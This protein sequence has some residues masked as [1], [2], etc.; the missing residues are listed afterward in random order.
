MSNPSGDLNGINLVLDTFRDVVV[1][2]G[3]HNPLNEYGIT[4]LFSIIGMLLV[5]QSLRTLLEGG[6]SRQLIAQ[7]LYLVMLGSFASLMITDDFQLKQK[8]IDSA[9][10]I[11][12]K[13]SPTGAGS[14]GFDAA[15]SALNVMFNAAFTVFDSEAPTA[16]FGQDLPAGDKGADPASNTSNG[17]SVWGALTNIGAY[18]GTGL[19]IALMTL[20]LKFFAMAIMILGGLIAMAQ[21][22]VSQILVHI[23]I[24]LAPIFIPFL[25]WEQASFLF[26]GWLKFHQG[27]VSQG[28]WFSYGGPAEF[29]GCCGTR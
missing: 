5:F 21:F 24:I 19:Q 12:D 28:C 20:L 10:M 4:L 14:S 15:S 3:Q 27:G 26:D 2:L 11:A 25:V 8:L 17:G 16:N 22:I 7:F 18:L 1:N 29:D 6:S 9:D 23:A 13:V